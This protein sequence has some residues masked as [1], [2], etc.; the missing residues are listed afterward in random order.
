MN[1]FRKKT[2]RLFFLSRKNA[3]KTLFLFCCLFF[4]ILSLEANESQTVSKITI[5][6]K[7]QSLESALNQLEKQSGYLFFYQDKIVNEST[8][9]NQKFEEKTISQILDVLFSNSVNSYAISGRQVV[10]YKKAKSQTNK[11]DQK[12][13]VKA[14]PFSIKGVVVDE[15]GEL[16][17]GASV[18]VEGEGVGTV[19]DVNGTFVILTNNTEAR[20]ITTYVG[21][22]P[23]VVHIRDAGLIKLEPNTVELKNMVVT[24]IY[25][26]KAESFTGAS[27]TLSNE[28]LARMGNQNVLQ[29][30]KLLDP[31]IYIPDNLTMG[32]DPNTMPSVSMRGTSSFP[33]EETSSSL[34]SNYENQ[35]NQ[36]LFIVDGFESSIEYIVD[37][38]MNRVESVTILKDASAK[39]MYG[40]KAANG[41]IVIET[42]RVLGN[43]QLITYNGSVTLEMPD[44]T[45]YNLTNALEKLQVELA[46]GLYTGN[47][48]AQEALTRLYNSRKKQALEGLNTYWL[49]KPLRTGVGQKH[50]ISLELGDSRSLRTFLDLTYNQTDGV[51]KE[52]Q[53]RNISGVANISYRKDKFLFKN[54][55]TITSNKSEDSPYGSFENYTKLNPYW[56]ATD[57]NGQVLR[58]ASTEGE[59]N[60]ANPLYDATIGTSLLSSYLEFINNFYTEWTIKP[61]LKTTLRIGVSGKRNDADSFYPALHSK[62]VKY[63]STVGDDLMKRGQ[64]TKENGKKNSLTADINVNYN[65]S[66]GLHSFFANAGAFISTDEYEAYQYTAEGFMNTQ[67]ADITFARRY[68]ENTVPVGSSSLN[69]QASF[70]GALSYD[71]DNR[72]LFDAT[73]RQSASSLY[74]S[75]KRWAGSWSLGLGWNLHKEAFMSGVNHI[76]I[77]KLRSSIGI[78]GNQNFRTNEAIATYQY[79]SGV[80][81]GGDGGYFTGAYLSNMPNSALKWE[82]K[83]DYNVGFDLQAFGVNMS[84]NYY[85]ADT[86]DMLTNVTIPTSTGFS[87][88]KGNLGLVRN[89]G[90]ELNANYKVWGDRNGALNV[91][92]TFVYNKNKIIDL[93]ES[94]RDYNK[95]AKEK[96]KTSRPLALY[97]DGLS[98]NTLWVV[99]SAGIDPATG[100]EVYIKKDGSY[101]YVHS[102]ED[103]VAV[104]NLDPKYRGTAGLS[105]EYKGIG[106]SMALSFLTGCKMYNQTLVDRVDDADISENVD[107]RVLL[108]RWQTPGQVTQFKKFQS[109]VISYPSSRFVQDRRELSLSALSA[110]YEIPASVYEKFKMKRLR[111]TFYMNDIATFSSVK[112][113]RGLT[114]PFARTMSFQLTGTF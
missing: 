112:I 98:M 93:S 62:F 25:E 97:E 56:Q 73:V 5:E 42:K 29:S 6:F 13:E 51:M 12:P 48:D 36:P 4:F 104:G 20:L 53:R 69:R 23:R 106:V 17:I 31:S 66:L 74:G 41:V 95:T 8:K 43:Q 9:V 3:I 54:I 47:D 83:K 101:T 27:T 82:Q 90:I 80:V 32:S 57:V 60:V 61:E 16:L 33:L 88:V 100:M 85:V 111:L 113:E 75:D 105:A 7:N 38:D 46:E 68:L 1:Y 49:S 110:Y 39:A 2:T 109:N 76:K 55:F 71:Y 70:L 52:S 89:S 30:L 11:Q 28:D 15:N 35:P 44:L 91:F 63:L 34:K 18:Q 108:G 86:K 103:L 50:N 96:V 22:K 65:K 21:Y 59:T 45:S 40:S 78:T 114:Y 87:S 24:G 99:P 81:Y 84:F 77:L 58:W 102:N 14:I 92:G 79:Y 10:I 26:R 107:R 19:T 94:M 67:V 37:L 64:Y 72:Y